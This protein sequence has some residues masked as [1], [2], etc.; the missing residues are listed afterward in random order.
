MAIASSTSR[1][2]SRP[3]RSACRRA[4]GVS[5]WPR[6]GGL[7]V[8]LILAAAALAATPAAAQTPPGPF[9]DPPVTIRSSGPLTSIFT[10]RRFQCQVSYENEGQY[11]PPDA[12][13]GDCRTYITLGGA[14]GRHA[15][16]TAVRFPHP[17][18]AAGDAEPRMVAAGRDR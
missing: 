13:F 9:A 12:Q 2:G 14:A 1:S 4:S 17:Q 3:S 5:L 16:R 6:L 15:L 11:F 10:G 18:L 8:A 7:V